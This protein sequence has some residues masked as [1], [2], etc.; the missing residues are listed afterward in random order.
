MFSY[1]LV[2]PFRKNH[3]FAFLTLT[4]VVIFALPARAQESRS[5]ASSN[6]EAYIE[7]IDA[8]AAHP[9]M[10]GGIDVNPAILNAKG[11]LCNGA[12]ADGASVLIIR[13]HPKSGQVPNGT[14]INVSIKNPLG[15][16]YKQTADFN[17][18]L[19][20][21][22]PGTS[23]FGFPAVPAGDTVAPTDLT[24][25]TVQS[26][27]ATGTCI[28]YYRPPNNFWFGYNHKDI[29]ITLSIQCSQWST[30]AVIKLTRTSII[31]AHGIL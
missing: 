1:Y 6:Q 22:S 19:W 25:L 3:R 28:F 17:G 10:K 23:G 29:P 13:L 9:N 16:A 24:A 12:L 7:I 20:P 27:D 2:S 21:Y 8:Q 15:G 31:V 5:S 18:S 14:Q 26:I 30:H 4:A 11:S